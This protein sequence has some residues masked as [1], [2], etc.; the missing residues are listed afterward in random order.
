MALEQSGVQLIA[1]GA[2]AYNADLKNATNATNTFVDSTEQGGGRVSGASQIMIG[3]LRQLGTIAVDA[4]MQAGKAAVAFVGDS[5]K[6]AGDFEQ[7]ML[8]FQAV[9]GKEV[10]A[11]GLKD[12]RDLFITLGKELPVSTMEVQQAAAEMVK[13]GIDPAIIAAGGLK[14]NIQ[15]A[16]A[17]MEGD[18]VKAAEISSKILGGWTDANATAAQKAD[19]LTH[20]T[21]MLTKA[22]NASAT[23]VEGLSRG[24]F[25]AQGIAKTAGVGF[26]DL[27]TTLALLAPRFAS[28]AEAGTS[29]KN[30]IARLQPT[31]DPA[32]QAMESLGLYTQD[33]GSAF[34]DAQGNFVGFE[35]ASQLLQDSLKGLTKEQQAATLQQI[36]GNDAMG[37]AAALADGGGEAYANMAQ[38]MNEANGV[39]DAAAL[40]QQGFNTSLDNAKGSVEA[41]QITIGSYLLPILGD[42]LDNYIAPAINAFTDWVSAIFDA[43]DPIK[44][45]VDQIDQFSPILGDV[46][47]VIADFV[48]SGGDLG[49]VADDLNESMDGLGD[50]FLIVTDGIQDI[51]TWF[52]TASDKTSD[53]GGAVN[54]LS[55]IWDKAKE[56]IT[57]VA[58]GYKDVIDSIFPQVQQFIKDHG[59]EIKAFFQET[60]DKIVEIVKLALD[61]YNETV[62][63]I[64]HAIAGFIDDH[65]SEIQKI[66]K[67]AWDAVSSIISG[68]LETI[69][70]TLKL[71]L[72]ILHGDW[73]GAWK[74]IQHIGEVQWEAIK[75]GISGFL[76]A[77]AGIFDT[78]FGDIVK[79]WENNWDMLVEIAGKVADKMVQIGADIVQGIID[80]VEGAAGQL[81]DALTNLASDAL[82]AAKDALGI[83]SPSKEFA[84]IGKFAI[85]GMM[86]GITETWPDMINLVGNISGDLIDEMTNIGRDMQNAIAGGFGATASID[87]QMAKNLDQIGE[88]QDEFTR[89]IVS[90]DLDAL[91]KKANS[92]FVDPKVAADY[93]KMVSNQEFE[94]LKIREQIAKAT[95]DDEKARLEQQLVLI[96]RA[97]DAE[98]DQFYAKQQ[99]QQSPGE[100]IADSINKVM[101]VLSGINLTDSQIAI[102]SLLANIRES[103][104]RP[105]QTSYPAY[106]GQGGYTGNTTNVNMPI[107]TN[108]TP[109]ALQ[110]SWAVLNASMP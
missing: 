8:N 95:T 92:L 5:I 2:D 26:D 33:T 59:E 66:L 108:N 34:Y 17:A 83:G 50:V 99:G 21:D 30:M 15:F 77:I 44:A 36:F 48:S 78:T 63:P 110:Q 102:V 54:D 6:V 9:A 94:T 89:K 96:S 42:L 85:Q 100:Q 3:A 19:F 93:Y 55:S 62:P 40:K 67:G 37:A 46:V 97:Q 90:Q 11:S 53:L 13:G 72:D 41:L 60:W 79:T 75:G 91:Q 25:Q 88:I 16:A 103:I 73:E 18:L 43:D 52:G 68:A 58:N 29:V 32:I 109:A 57:N 84:T 27:T 14:Q 64:L 69:K 98:L 61:V 49:V 12:F 7:G 86:E 56:T 10:D 105:P 81:M 104:V 31:T 51:V 1:Q 45:L 22:A 107:Y 80:G 24:I 106:T 20:S 76:D 4:F 39:A 65:G 38:K 74:D 87:R 23:D 47:A 82:Q 101:G 70:T 71:A 35:T 28:S